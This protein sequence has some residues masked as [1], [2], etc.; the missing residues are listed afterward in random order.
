MTAWRRASHAVKSILIALA[1]IPLAAAPCQAASAADLLPGLLR[2]PLPV[3]VTL[4]TGRQVTLE[5]LVIRPDQPGRFPLAVM[6]HGTPRLAP[7]GLA[8]TLAGVSPASFNA[9]AIA[10]AQRGYAAVAILRRGFGTSDGPYAEALPAG[11]TCDHR[12]YLPL[13]RASGEDVVAAVASLREQPWVDRDRVLLIGLSTGGV[14]VTAAAATPQAGVVGVLSFAGGRGST[15]PDTVCSPEALIQT[16]GQLGRTAHI[17]ALWIY[18]ENDH[19]FSPDF[20]RRLHAAYT[21]AGAPAQ[22][23]LLPPFGADGHALLSS[24]PVAAWWPTVEPFLAARGLP[25]RVIITLPPLP[26]LAAPAWVSSEACR[27]GFKAFAESRIDAKAYAAGSNGACGWI[28]RARSPADA[29]ADA[30]KNCMARSASCTLYA[31]GH[32]LVT[33]E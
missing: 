20:A 14:A 18:A 29:G 9:A 25:T 13:A 19:F 27:N 10:F 16:F 31:V 8:A 17:P 11:S 26:T 12:D 7:G 21:E 24:A 23:A 5:G 22:F 15:A 2:G 32:R 3:A 28:L 33:S 30:L 1:A 4:P 6:V